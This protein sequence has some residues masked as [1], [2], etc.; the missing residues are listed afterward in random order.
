MESHRGSGILPGD[1][2][3]PDPAL[4]QRETRV[5][6]L[7]ELQRWLTGR[8]CQDAKDIC[9][10]FPATDDLVPYLEAGSWPA[11]RLY[12][13]LQLLEKDNNYILPPIDKMDRFQFV[14]QWAVSV[15]SDYLTGCFRASAEPEI[16][17]AVLAMGFVIYDKLPCGR[18]IESFWDHSPFA[19]L[20]EAPPLTEE[21]DAESLEEEADAESLEE[22]SEPLDSESEKPAVSIDDHL[23]I[24]MGLSYKVL[25]SELMIPVPVWTLVAGMGCVTAYMAI[26][27]AAI[28]RCSVH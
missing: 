26:L 23:D 28:G 6:I 7:E 16:P 20:R 21:A 18:T 4:T 24:V 14:G 19:P 17:A 9:I 25:T 1:F 5:Y 2:I 27:V 3:K 11:A 8:I 22:E 13:V 10:E 12:A 15:C